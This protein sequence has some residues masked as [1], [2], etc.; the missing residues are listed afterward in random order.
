MSKSIKSGKEQVVNALIAYM[1]PAKT[2]KQVEAELTRQREEWGTKNAKLIASFKKADKDLLI[3][4]LVDTM[5][6]RE[7]VEKSWDETFELMQDYK[8]MFL[9]AVKQ[10]PEMRKA[11]SKQVEAFDK[12]QAALYFGRMKGA[13]SQKERAAEVWGRVEQVNNDLLTNPTTSRWSLKQRASYI[14]E[15]LETNGMLQT[16]GKPYSF[17]TIYKRITGKG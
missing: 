4:L 2:A 12:R 17:G 14:A 16:N 10:L 5:F 7:R 15:H 8:S 11:Y 9:D 13:K 1:Q 6:W 3:L